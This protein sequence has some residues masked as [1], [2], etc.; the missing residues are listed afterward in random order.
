MAWDPAVKSV[1]LVDFRGPGG[2]GLN[3][4]RLGSGSWGQMSSVRIGAWGDANLAVFDP[5]REL[6]LF[7]GDQ[8]GAAV[9]ASTVFDGVNLVFAA[10]QVHPSAEGSSVAA[11]YDPDVKEVVAFGGNSS[12]G[13]TAELWAWD[14][15]RWTPLT[16]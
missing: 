16:G 13:Q 12:Q 4:W 15:Q 7:Y 11:T 14:F 5:G 1:T 8:N 6:W 3:Y 2:P 9:Y 10:P